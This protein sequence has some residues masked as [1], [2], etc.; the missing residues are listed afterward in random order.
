MP[1]PRIPVSS[2]E[3]I[4]EWDFERNSELG[5]D[6]NVL[7]TGNE[8]KV[9]WKCPKCGYSWRASIQMRAKHKTGCAVCKGLKILPGYNDLMT[10]N[11]D[12]MN[13]WD[14]K[15][16]N[17]IGLYPYNV[18]PG[19]IRKAWWKCP[20][21][22]P[23]YCAAIS[24]RGRGK[25]CAV[26]K[27][28]KA[29][30]GTNDLATKR[31]DLLKQWNYEKNNRL[32]ITPESITAGSTKKVW[33]KCRKGHEWE[34]SVGHIA[35]GSGCPQCH[36]GTST[37][38]PEQAIFYYLKQVDD[39]CIN[40]FRLDNHELDIFIPDKKIGIEYNGFRWHDTIEKHISD[41]SKEDFFK[42]KGID[43]IRII[44]VSKKNTNLGSEFLELNNQFRHEYYVNDDDIA[45]LSDV[46]KNLVQTLF[47]VK[48]LVDINADRSKIYESYIHNEESWSFAME[49]DKCK[50]KWDYER[51]GNLKPEYVS[52]RSGKVVYWLCPKGHSFEGSVHTINE[53]RCP[54]C[55]NDQTY[56]NRFG[57]TYPEL[58][59]EWDYEKNTNVSPDELT[60]G[61]TRKV[62]WKCNNGHKSWFAPVSS[63]VKGHGCPVCGKMKI[64]EKKF[65][66]V[67]QYTLDGKLI[68]E[69]NSALTVEETLGISRSHIGS[70]CKGLRKKAGG[71][72]WKYI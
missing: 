60:C 22:H 59:K 32:G 41:A 18:G 9:W 17:E 15:K 46:I 61:S 42:E 27:N 8:S 50:F 11:P 67:A 5:L 1:Q 48:L 35:R 14:F 64:R 52:R 56:S 70:V 6:P 38:F 12:L 4:K 49:A 36:N 55:A 58:L 7:T 26:C 51:N 28:K 33:W 62:W 44:E 54:I 47:G 43:V 31:P 53:R 39:S 68:K 63:R 37:S 16:N 2:T 30:S 72:I 66:P 34:A 65:K 21:G 24:D 71:F 23:S 69:W 3:L 10:K 45:G 13:E 20:N 57:L 19:T 29:L 40:R 25:G